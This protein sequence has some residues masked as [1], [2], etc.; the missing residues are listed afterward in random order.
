MYCLKTWSYFSERLYRGLYRGTLPGS[1]SMTW[2]C[3]AIW[4]KAP[5]SLSDKRL[6]GVVWRQITGVIVFWR[7]RIPLIWLFSVSVGSKHISCDLLIGS[8]R[9]ELEGIMSNRYR[10]QTRIRSFHAQVNA[11]RTGRAYV[12]VCFSNPAG[13]FWPSA[14]LQSV[15]PLQKSSIGIVVVW[16]VGVSLLGIAQLCNNCHGT[17]LLGT[18]L[19]VTNNPYISRF[20]I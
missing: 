9:S 20:C 5:A 17:N 15:F 8:L 10:G 18:S 12:A 3:S 16:L 4:A 19:H 6:R 14:G 1:S 11:S 2:S 7:I 13:T